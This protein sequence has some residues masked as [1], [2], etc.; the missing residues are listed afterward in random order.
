MTQNI[1]FWPDLSP[2]DIDMPDDLLT[3]WNCFIDFAVKHW[4]GCRTTESGYTRDIG[5]IEIWL[6]DWLMKWWS[7]GLGIW[8][9]PLVLFEPLSQVSVKCLSQRT[10]FMFL[11]QWDGVGKFMPFILPNRVSGTQNSTVLE[12]YPGYMSKVCST[13]EDQQRHLHCCQ[14]YVCFYVMP[15]R[16]VSLSYSGIEGIWPI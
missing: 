7:L 6:I 16:F 1:S 11:I 3:L 10:L 14:G 13:A 15:G 4:F 2:I 8:L 5:A 9:C 12:S